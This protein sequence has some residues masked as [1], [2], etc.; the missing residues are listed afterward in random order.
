MT[1]VVKWLRRLA[2]EADES[3]ASFLGRWA[4]AN[5]LGTRSRL[6][7]SLGLPTSVR[8]TLANSEKLAAM[9]GL[10]SS[11]LAAIAP[12]N[13]P[14]R[15]VLRRNLTRPRD[16]AFCPACLAE[17]SYSRQL[18]SHGLATA[19]PV[20]RTRLLDQCAKCGN[21]IGHER[22]ISHL[23]RCGADLRRQWSEVAT[24]A[25]VEFADLL[26]GAAPS[27]HVFPFVF[28]E[29]IPAELDLFVVGLANYFYRDPSGKSRSKPG[30]VALPG[31][32]DD[33]L[34]RLGPAFELLQDWPANFDA[35]LEEMM[36]RS[37]TITSTG[38]SMRLGAW[39][40]FLFRKYTQ[41]AFEPIRIAAANRIVLSHDGALN[42]RTGN[43]VSIATVEKNW[44]SVRES[45]ELL[46][47]TRDRIN[48][49]IDRGIIVARIH[50]EA[51]GYRQRFLHKVEINR[52]V[53]VQAEHLSEA[54]ARQVLGVS[55]SIFALIDEAGLVERAE[56]FA[57]EPVVSGL[58]LHVPLLRLIKRLKNAMPPGGG[59]SEAVGV[60]LRDLNLRRTTDRQRLVSLFRAIGSGELTPIGDDDEHGIGGMMFRQSDVDARV[61]S[62]FVSRGLTVE[63]VSELTSTH[64][65]AV[66]GWVDSGLL[67]ASRE[68]LEQGAPWVI[69]LK[70]LVRFLL[71]YAPLATQAAACG[72]TSRGL[73]A[74]LERR[75]AK[76]IG[77]P[78]GRGSVIKVAA[79]FELLNSKTGASDE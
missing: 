49:G 26:T 69:E 67:P 73:A 36:A 23:C 20:H 16:E 7:R 64:Y 33:A 72:S 27:Q 22:G 61:A 57:V 44:Y 12:S 10:E 37:P 71:A 1:R 75:G 46:G 28:E 74:M 59:Q 65:D 77:N 11:V 56:L 52:L 79:L 4:R 21:R 47:V 63:Q 54:T 78:S 66:K 29:G 48:D 14:A 34:K 3:L 40:A 76:P 70:A 25:E 13:D 17:S 58:V 42:A 5:A 15:P 9:L 60:H 62:W 31:S 50:D 38:V 24:S 30:K 43:V 32:V 51:A 45:A 41:P 2:P 39:Y 55:K 8:I 19:C 53:A 18:W 68:P 35:R 6:L